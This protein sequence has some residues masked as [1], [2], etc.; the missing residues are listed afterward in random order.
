MQCIKYDKTFDVLS[1]GYAMCSVV[2]MQCIRYHKTFHVSS[3]ARE[4]V[5]YWYSFGYSLILLE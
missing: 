2:H 1:S 5:I 4:G 3:I